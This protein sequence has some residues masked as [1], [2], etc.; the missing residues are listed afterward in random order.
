VSNSFRHQTNLLLAV[1]VETEIEIVDWSYF[2]T[3]LH[4]MKAAEQRVWMLSRKRR[5]LD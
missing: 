2:Q 5:E 3:T 4:L 1:E